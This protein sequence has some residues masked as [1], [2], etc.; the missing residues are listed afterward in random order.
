MCGHEGRMVIFKED[1]IGAGEEKMGDREK[2]KE[3]EETTSQ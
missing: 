3:N 2:A 1:G